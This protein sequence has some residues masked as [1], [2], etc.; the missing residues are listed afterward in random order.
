VGDPC[1]GPN[2]LRFSIVKPSAGGV[3]TGT[4]LRL[5]VQASGASGQVYTLSWSG[6]PQAPL[7]LGGD[8]NAEITGY[9]TGN[10]QVK[11]R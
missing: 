3:S 11:V 4:V 6:I 2:E 8:T 7:V 1:P 10:G 5:V 9:S